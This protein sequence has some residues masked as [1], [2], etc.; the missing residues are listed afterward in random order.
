[1]V[2][3]TRLTVVTINL[4]GSADRWLERRHL[5][6]AQLLDLDADL[7]GLQEISFPVGQGRWIC[8][9]INARMAS[10][11]RRQYRLI[12][13]RKR[14]LVKGYF[15][16]IGVLSR[17]PIVYADHVGLGYGGRLALRVNVE[18]PSRQTLDFVCLHLHHL[19]YEPEAR[20]EQVMR[21]CGWLQERRRN[22]LQVVVGD[23]N[24][25]PSGP[26]IQ[27]MKK[28]FRSAYAECYGH[29]PLATF[30]TALVPSPDGWSGCL[31]YIFLSP[32]VGGK[33]SAALCCN[34]PSEDDDTLFASD[35][36]GIVAT[37]E[38]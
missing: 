16:G 29:E 12:Q 37:I 1:V 10:A 38:V 27:I 9:Q 17:L 32:A 21:L 25:L 19:A 4:R 11:E 14:H 18:L 6:V 31:D 30:P 8:N 3:K 7:V 2:G 22:P 33:V 34:K 24:E 20:N 5:L 28:G 23:F 13:R 36:V 15:E 35:H 26:A